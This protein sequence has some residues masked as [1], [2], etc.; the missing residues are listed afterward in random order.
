[1]AGGSS[2]R[3]LRLEV[4][5]NDDDYDATNHKFPSS[6][7]KVL[8]NDDFDY[9]HSHFIFLNAYLNSGYLS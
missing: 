5:T 4:V 9:Q 7:Y 8:S 6:V 2:G 1:M 3:P